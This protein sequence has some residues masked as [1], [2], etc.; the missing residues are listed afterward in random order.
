MGAKPTLEEQYTAW[1]ATYDTT[2]L[3]WEEDWTIGL[4]KD[5]EAVTIGRVDREYHRTFGGHG[6]WQ[7]YYAES[8]WPV[9]DQLFGVATK[10]LAARCAIRAYFLHTLGWKQERIAR[11]IQQAMSTFER[12]VPFWELEPWLLGADLSARPR[13]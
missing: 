13:R 6:C 11:A 1:R 10:E 3:Y 8:L 7:A 5:G 12:G 9:T 4:Y 2:C